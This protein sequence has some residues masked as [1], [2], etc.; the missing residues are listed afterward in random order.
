MD[1]ARTEE[2]QL[3]ALKK[4]WAQNGISIIT[5]VVLG[6]VAIF[7]W[8]GWQAHLQ[9]QAEAASGLYSELIVNIRQEK[10]DEARVQAN[11]IL[12]NYEGTG[13]AQFAALLLARIEIDGNNHDAAIKQLHWVMDNAKQE[14]L[15]HLARL[16]IARLYLS[17]DKPKL[18]L[19]LLDV[20]D[21]GSFT[22]SYEETR[23]DI[24]IRLNQPDKAREAYK[25]ALSTINDTTRENSYLQ[26][27]LDDIGRDSN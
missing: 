7:G 15:K 17:D 22:A 8:R 21:Y 14:E 18:A 9:E 11:E 23:G 3:E 26:L 20:K 13:Y 12:E 16:R 5:G 19:E 25:N 1:V 4:W 27:K 24:Y 10:L 6:I 2:E